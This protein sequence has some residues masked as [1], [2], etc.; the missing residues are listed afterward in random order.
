MPY[1]VNYTDESQSRRPITVFD[2][3]SNTDTSLVFPGRNVTG[4][5][6]TIAENFLHLLENFSNSNPPVNP[7]RGQIWFNSNPE[8]LSLLIWDGSN[9]KAAS[10]VQKSPVEPPTEQT[11]V[12]ELWVDT[13]NQQLYV[14]SGIDWILVGPNFSTGLRSGLVVEQVTDSADIN[15]VILSVYVEDRPIIIISK[16]SFTP[17]TI[18]PQFSTIR[19][20]VNVAAPNTSIEQETSIYQG[21]FLPRVFGTASSADALNVAGISVESNKFLRTDI[22]NVVE[23]SFNVKNDAGITFGADGTFNISTSTT[24]AKLWNT[25]AGSGIDLQITDS[26]IPTTVLRVIDNKVGINVLSPRESLDIQGNFQLR[27]RMIVTDDTASTNLNN[28]S[29]QTAGGLA[30]GSNAI[31]GQSLEVRGVTTSNNIVPSSNETYTLGSDPSQGGR[32]WDKIFSKEINADIITGQITGSITGNA[33]TATRLQNPTQFRMIGDVSSLPFDFNGITGGTTKTFDTSIATGFIT[34]KQDV[35]ILQSP[36]KNYSLRDDSVLIFRASVS[37]L[38]KA[39]RD[40]F[41]GDLGIPIGGI[42]PYAGTAIPF[43]FL[44]CD[45]S[46]VL[47]AKHP[48]LF[49]AIGITYNG[50]SPLIGFDTFRLPDLRARFPLGRDNMDNGGQVAT[51]GGAIVDA[52]GG[53]VD[54]I[55]GI[56]PDTLGGSGG[57]GQYA[58]S[59]SNLP[60]HEHDM[61]GS[62]NQRYYATRLDTTVP[63]DT[64]AFLGAGGTTPNR[65]QYLPSSGGIKLSA[66]EVIGQPYPVVNPF[67]TINYIIRTGAPAF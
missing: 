4:Y 53:N 23:N 51:P 43:G 48:E 3:T 50:A 20:G 34:S 40:T 25:S 55:S 64:G 59:I 42:L 36:Q 61:Q 16:D 21:G 22:V 18:I 19:S 57:A 1:T 39:N 44:L 2:N 26:G 38:L 60:E 13:I 6:Q 5:G 58:L 37:G 14:F 11:K 67:L 46:E 31:I 56:E 45:G 41:V 54:R 10:G 35:S 52:G 29:I 49:Q 17:K 32:R 9:W 66:G 27:G 28:G 15:R 47:I 7:T 30:V 62:T 63:L 24:A 65:V 12:G 8:V 33:A